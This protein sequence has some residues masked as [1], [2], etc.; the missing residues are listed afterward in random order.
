MLPND[1]HPDLFDNTEKTS[2]H[3]TQVKIVTMTAFQLSWFA[4]IWLVSPRDFISNQ[5][6]N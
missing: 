1:Y 3:W 2:N 4:F 5:L 6:K